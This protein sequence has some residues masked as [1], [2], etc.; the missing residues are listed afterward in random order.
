MTTKPRTR[1]QIEKGFET[2]RKAA[3]GNVNVLHDQFEKM[4]VLVQQDGDVLHRAEFRLLE[5]VSGAAQGTVSAVLDDLRQ[6][7]DIFR[8]NDRPRECSVALAVQAAW[9]MAR[10]YLGSAIRCAEAALT[11]AELPAEARFNVTHIVLAGH[12]LLF[13]MPGAWKAYET[14]FLPYMRRSERTVYLGRALLG[15]AQLHIDQATRTAKLSGLPNL[16]V[17]ECAPTWALADQAGSQTDL[18]RAQSYIDEAREIGGANLQ[19]HIALIGS[20]IQALEGDVDGALASTSAWPGIG[21]HE[22]VRSY[23]QS[24]V[25][26]VNG[27]FPEALAMAR[28]AAQIA[29]RLG[30]S[31]IRR[32]CALELSLA[33]TMVGDHGTALR[34]YQ[35]LLQMTTQ[36]CADI[37]GQAEGGAAQREATAAFL[38]RRVEQAI[39]KTHASPWTPP[40]Y[41]RTQPGFLSQAIRV[42]EQSPSERT[43][44]EEVAGQVGVKTRTLQ[45]AFKDFRSCTFTEFRRAIQMRAAAAKL[46]TTDLPLQDIAAGLGYTQSP[47]F[48]RSFKRVYGLAPLEYRK[49]T[50]QYLLAMPAAASHDIDP[51]E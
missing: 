8:A 15:L 21:I 38:A 37:L 27:R 12:T 34:E 16:D 4:R 5:A 30:A 35:L 25:L 22:A 32:A 49:Q 29:D 18:A 23:R 41:R 45:A 47:G 33:S 51:G 19:P 43:P 28:H 17:A 46:E 48:I 44:I 20:S 13:D 24:W 7:E 14:H 3:W 40:Q 6:A 42:I 1:R 10:G 11:Y 39:T 50:R 31:H 2:L 36:T 9:E 26:R